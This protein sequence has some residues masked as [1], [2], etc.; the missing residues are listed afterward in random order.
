MCEDLLHTLQVESS[1]RQP[2]QKDATAAGNLSMS[3]VAQSLQSKWQSMLTQ[4]GARVPVEE[5]LE[6]GLF[7]NVSNVTSGRNSPMGSAL[8]AS[9]RPGQRAP[10][11]GCN[12]STRPYPPKASESV[13]P[14]S[15]CH[16]G[17]P[18][19]LTGLLAA[20]TPVITS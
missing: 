2:S 13:L 6:E 18:A 12:V 1:A 10:L 15:E 19:M 3:M 20:Q 11:I 14:L 7:G 5:L 17:R 16:T 9:S 4:Q 8:Q